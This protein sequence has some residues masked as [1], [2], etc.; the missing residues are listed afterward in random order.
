MRW[1]LPLYFL[2]G[3]LCAVEAATGGMVR[4]GEV[5]IELVSP[6]DAAEPGQ[7][8]EIGVRF[9]MDENWHIYW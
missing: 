2:L 7:V 5:A 3:G 4:D 6:V 1:F 8:I 9:R